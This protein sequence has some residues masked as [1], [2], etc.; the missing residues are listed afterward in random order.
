ML[1]KEHQQGFYLDEFKYNLIK[2]FFLKFEN[3]AFMR[4]SFPLWIIYFSDWSDTR[5]ILKYFADE[6]SN[7]DFHETVKALHKDLPDSE[8]ERGYLKESDLKL[9]FSKILSKRKFLKSR[10]YGLLGL[11]GDI[12]DW[13]P[14]FLCFERSYHTPEEF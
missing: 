11:L 9:Y 12:P 14:C 2:D 3:F 6:V 7:E 1:G 10:L 5:P 8:L 4:G 13:W